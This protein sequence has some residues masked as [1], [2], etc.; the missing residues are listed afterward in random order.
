M[1]WIATV[2]GGG[3]VAGGMIWLLPS[4]RAGLSGFTPI[5]APGSLLDAGPMAVIVATLVSIA[6]L[7]L[8]DYW[9]DD[10]EAA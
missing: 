7:W 3:L 5:A 4:L 9:A 10:S 2:F 1:M 6:G 8:A